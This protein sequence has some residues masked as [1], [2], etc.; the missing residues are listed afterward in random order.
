M[1]TSQKSSI[2]FEDLCCAFVSAN[3]L[4][5]KLCN[6]VLKQFLQEKHTK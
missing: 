4:I 3:I 1:S 2:F 6:P 5:H